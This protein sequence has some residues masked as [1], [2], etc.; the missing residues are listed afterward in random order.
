MQHVTEFKIV[1]ENFLII[2]LTALSQLCDKSVNKTGLL[3]FQILIPSSKTS[4]AILYKTALT[5][6]AQ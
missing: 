4:L 1:F 6:S 2:F 3:Y 5:C